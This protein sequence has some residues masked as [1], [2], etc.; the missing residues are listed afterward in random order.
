MTDTID[1]FID[2]CYK[3]LLDIRDAEENLYSSY[4]ER[5]LIQASFHLNTIRQFDRYKNVYD[6][7][8]RE[9][10]RVSRLYEQTI[11]GE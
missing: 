8:C 4:S 2:E 5:K 1:L 3:A 11:I 9:Y 6:D 10:T 7:I